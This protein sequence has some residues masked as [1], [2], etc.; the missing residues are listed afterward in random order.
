MVVTVDKKKY[1]SKPFDITGSAAPATPVA[2]DNSTATVGLTK[3]AAQAV[4][5]LQVGIKALGVPLVR[6]K[7]FVEIV[8][9]L[10][11]RV[12]AYIQPNS[13]TVNGVAAAYVGVRGQNLL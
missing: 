11:F 3:T 4:T 12:P 13:V 2:V 9:P 1:W 5:G 10:D 6:N 7:D 8:L